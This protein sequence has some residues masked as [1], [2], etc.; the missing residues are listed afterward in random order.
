MVIEIALGVS[1]APLAAG[2]AADPG[3][4]VRGAIG[5]AFVI[6]LAFLA[7][8]AV[9]RRSS[10]AVCALVMVAAAAAN[11]FS[12][13]GFFAPPGESVSVFLKGVFA[14]SVLIFLSATI[15]AARRNPV[16]G[17]LMFAAALSLVGIGV[18]N[19]FGRVEAA[20]LMR[21]GLVGAGAF[22][23]A[24]AG[25]QAVR[26]DHGARLMLPGILISLAAPIAV[27]VFGASPLAGH[28][29][30]AFGVLAVSLVALTEGGAPVSEFAFADASVAFNAEDSM[31]D[32][33]KKLL[34]SENQLAQVLD[35]SGVAVWDWSPG[36]AHQTETFAELFGARAHQRVAPSRLIEAV[37]ERDQSRFEEHVFGRDQGDGSFDLTVR[38]H[39][40]DV[41]RLRGARAVREDGSLER[42]VLFAER[43]GDDAAPKLWDAAAAGAAGAAGAMAMNAVQ[44]D[45]AREQKPKRSAT[46]DAVA[47]ALEADKLEAAF[48]PI[49]SLSDQ[50]VQG[51]EA[52]L[53]PAE[54]AAD[55]EKL[56]TEEIVQ[57]AE[58]AGR[59]GALAS[60]MLAQSAAFLADKIR[61]R[62]RKQ[63]FVA[64]NVS[65][66]QIRESSFLD[67]VKSAVKTH[68]L[69]EKS[70]VLELTE[71]EAVTDE[72]AA[73]NVFSRLKDAGVALAFD[74]FGV[75]F[76]SLSNL[77]KYS[78]DYLK[79]D[80][81]FVDKLGSD[82]D[83]EKIVSAVAKLGSDLGLTV[84]AEGLET[85]ALAESAQKCGCKLGQGFAFGEAERTQKAESLTK[86]G[87]KP[88]EPS[89][90]KAAASA[91]PDSSTDAA[92]DDASA[93]KPR[94]RFWSAD[95]R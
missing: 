63:L 39:Q 54:G 43:A 2:V 76:S 35:Y 24:L 88:S 66:A 36:N 75:G 83:A 95:L 26:G 8:F 45:P 92:S 62:K 13:L 11:E 73:S 64:M 16:L 52:L 40:D 42:L 46:A 5:G 38:S 23:L 77:H 25:F 91:K 82:A 78:F 89:E 70:L 86:D 31:D 61:S 32:E 29:L 22:A 60:M 3:D 21:I 67:A 85:K 44:N 84:I 69:P 33:T 1:S 57:A 72:A 17:G 41:I 7:G 55:L 53:R 6:G 81:S 90:K 80:K 20:G 15:G 58:Q 14:A 59:G 4:L 30:F 34:V 19:F 74:D 79:V 94:R 48:Q 28:A 68:A 12:A 51:Y 9:F 56:S 18:I 50:S 10:P 47:K 87:A 65:Y 49:V 37:H 71:S 27:M 93:P